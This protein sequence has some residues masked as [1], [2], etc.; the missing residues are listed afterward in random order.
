MALL[1]NDELRAHVTTGDT[2]VLRDERGRLVPPESGAVTVIDIQTGEINAMVSAPSY[3]PNL[4]SGRLSLRDWKRLNEHPRTP[5]LNRAISGLY[6]PGSTFK[7]VVA[8][9][10]L[11]AGV[12]SP[13]SKIKCEGSFDFGQRTFHCWNEKGHG[14][15]DMISS[16]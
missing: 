8:A 16:L 2:L 1:K 14:F 10:A 9:A 12:I 15:V 13:S 7:M 3:D 11:E 5:L 6:A 4:F